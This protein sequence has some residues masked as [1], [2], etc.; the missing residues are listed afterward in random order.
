MMDKVSEVDYSK[1]DIAPN[2]K[3]QIQF[4]QFHQIHYKSITSLR[5]LLDIELV[6]VHCIRRGAQWHSG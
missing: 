5:D 1:Y 4:I 2:F 3:F 6:I